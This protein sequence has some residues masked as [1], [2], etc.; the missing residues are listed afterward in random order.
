MLYLLLF[1]SLPQTWGIVKGSH[2]WIFGRMAITTVDTGDD[3][4]GHH[5]GLYQRC[6][7]G[8]D[9]MWRHERVI[10]CMKLAVLTS[11]C[12]FTL[13]PKD[14]MLTRICSLREP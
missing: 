6:G 4:G 2:N 11:K 12:S 3:D 1:G 13:G 14:K 10:A 9:S 5:L 8:A 7:T